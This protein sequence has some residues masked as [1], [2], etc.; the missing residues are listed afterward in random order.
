MSLV[1]IH[2]TLQK[3]LYTQSAFSRLDESDDGEFYIRDRFVNHLDATALETVERIIRELVIEEHAVMLD[4][5]AGWD[6]HVAQEVRPARLIGLGLNRN[7]LAENR[8]LTEW[9]YHDLNRQPRLPFADRTFDVVLNTVSIDYM[10][11]P[12]AVFAEIGRILK[13]GGL[14]L[15]VFSNRMFRQKAV[16]IWRE[17]SEDERLLIVEDYFRA[18]ALFAAPQTFVSK[19]RPRPADD[20]YAHLGIPSDPIYAVYAERAGWDTGLGVRSGRPHPQALS[21]TETSLDPDEIERRKARI[22]ETLRCPHCDQR[23]SKWR[24]PQTPFTE[25]NNEFMYICFND[26]C[27][28]LIRGWDTMNRQGN[29]GLSYRLM[30]NPERDCC[31]PVPVPSLAALKA[32]I[33]SE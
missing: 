5:M 23:L 4:L 27:P 21:A 22:A 31:L 18:S 12:F 28:Y 17:A 15:V 2:E 9:V 25:W 13:P 30:Y 14:F 16:K 3:H 19:G 11:E 29:M 33:V 24:V 32:G 20:K 26:T 1:G 7:E 6:S 10:T 8:A